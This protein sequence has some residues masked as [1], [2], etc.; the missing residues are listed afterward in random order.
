M[1]GLGTSQTRMKSLSSVSIVAKGGSIKT[2]CHSVDAE[3]GHV[4]K[5]DELVP[6]IDWIERRG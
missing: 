5:G 2:Y 6:R 3:C 4:D 1:T